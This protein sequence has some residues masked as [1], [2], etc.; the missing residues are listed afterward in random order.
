[1]VEDDPDNRCYSLLVQREGC[2]GFEVVKRV[3]IRLLAA[4]LHKLVDDGE[5]R[6][7]DIAVNYPGLKRLSRKL[8]AD[9]IR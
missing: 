5:R 3:T 8:I 9:K 2:I 1:V 4:D 6:W 7:S